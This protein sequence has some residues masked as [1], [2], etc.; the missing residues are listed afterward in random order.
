MALTQL[1]RI[2][3]S[4][5]QRVIFPTHLLFGRLGIVHYMA[6]PTLYCCSSH[7]IRFLSLSN[8]HL[9][10]K[11][12]RSWLLDADH[13]DPQVPVMII[14][15]YTSAFSCFTFNMPMKSSEKLR[16]STL[17][18][19]RV[20]SYPQSDGRRTLI[21]KNYGQLRTTG[22]MFLPWDKGAKRAFPDTV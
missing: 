3:L 5:S 12:S 20:R 4:C 21:F 17:K 9:Q 14:A 11:H 16:E 6:S 22:P 2:V 13:S 10:F 7:E 18:R 15:G 1:R 19:R 8:V